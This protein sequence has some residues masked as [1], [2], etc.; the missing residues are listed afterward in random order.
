[1]HDGKNL[2]RLLFVTKLKDKQPK[3]KVSWEHDQA[4][5]VSTDELQNIETKFHPFYREALRYIEKH[6]LI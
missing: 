2:V 5:W 1:V 3:I 6:K 4:N